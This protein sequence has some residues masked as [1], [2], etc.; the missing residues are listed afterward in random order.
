MSSLVERW[1]GNAELVVVAEI[2]YKWRFSCFVF[3]S[4]SNL[5]SLVEFA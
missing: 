2:A 3:V 4:D 5:R 1:K